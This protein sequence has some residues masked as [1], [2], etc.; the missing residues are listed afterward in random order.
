[1]AD[2][3]SFAVSQD[4]YLVEIRNPVTFEIL[5][6]DEGVPFSIGVLSSDTNKS[7]EVVGNLKREARKLIKSGSKSVEKETE[8]AMAE[9][10]AACTTSCNLVLDGKKVKHSVKEM[11][12]LFINPEYNWLKD[13]VSAAMDNRANFIKSKG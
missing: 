9:T 1:M 4:E 13:Q 10:I 11:K 7:R 5:Q 6:D 2:L 12:K 8:N 3:S